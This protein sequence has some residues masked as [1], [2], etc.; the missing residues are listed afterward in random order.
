VTRRKPR[1]RTKPPEPSGGWLDSHRSWIAGAILFVLAFLLRIF[2]WQATPDSSWPYSSFYRG[3]ALNWLQ[4]ADT[5]QRGLLLQDG[6]PLRPPGMAYLVALLWDGSMS[7][8]G[9]LKFLWC[10]LGSLTVALFYGAVLRAFGFFVAILAGF[11]AACSTALMLLSTS[12]NN[13]IPY[14]LLVMAAFC[15]HHRLLG[16]PTLWILAVW[17]V[18]HSLAC[19]VRV[20]HVLFYASVLV[21]YFVIWLRGR[22]KVP[23]LGLL[24]SLTMAALSVIL[25]LLPLVPWQIHAWRNIERF[26]AV[27]RPSDEALTEEALRVEERIRDMEWDRASLEEKEELP[28]FVRRLASDF[29][30]ATVLHRGG[31][32]VRAEDFR[33]LE[34]AFGYRPEPLGRLP[35]ITSYGPLNFYLA[36]NPHA[37]GGFNRFGLDDLPPLEGGASRYSP[38]LLLEPLAEGMFFFDWPPHLEAFNHGYSMGWEWIRTHP[39]RFLGLVGKKLQIFW[40][41]ATLGFTG[42]NIPLGLSGLQRAVDLV[43]PRGGGG[44]GLWRLMALVLCVWGIV[45]GRRRLLLY[46][47]FLFLASKLVM[48]VLFYG[49]ARIG[50]TVAPVIFLFVVLAVES[51]VTRW[52]PESWLKGAGRRRDAATMAA[53]VVVLIL[54]VEGVRFGIGPRVRIDDLEIGTTDPHSA[55]IHR[56]REI[57]VAL[58]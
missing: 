14:L 4:Y 16:R 31:Q 56:D 47:W 2:F 28:G 23:S 30:A 45:V 38:D 44:I 19:L 48:V 32:R 55:R 37:A 54:L 11:A 20:E 52:I 22:G 40:S 35:F 3:D 34:E 7:G 6:L 10:L 18:L 13:E 57:E 46:P 9:L 58:R 27:V 39:S 36:N 25:F 24:R 17:S 50:A 29:V 53:F 8:I 49:Y 21:F 42:F 12:L 43:V 5:I 51:F 1:Q 33:I 26:N 41:G 15:L